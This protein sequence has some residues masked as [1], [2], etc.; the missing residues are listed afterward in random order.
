MSYT[1][2][3]DSLTL[4]IFLL[5]NKERHNFEAASHNSY[6]TMLNWQRQFLP[7]LIG[8]SFQGLWHHS[9]SGEW[10]KVFLIYADIGKFRY[11]ARR[12]KFHRQSLPSGL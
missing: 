11:P 6:F 1:D 2:A 9:S 8:D 10:S 3:P 7:I 5:C 12:I 4:K